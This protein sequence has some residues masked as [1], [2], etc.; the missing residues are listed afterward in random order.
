MQTAATDHAGSVGFAGPH[1]APVT[2]CRV[3]CAVVRGPGQNNKCAVLCVLGGGRT[4]HSR[5]AMAARSTGLP[6]LAVMVSTPSKRSAPGG[7]RFRK[8][9]ITGA[10]SS[11][12]STLSTNVSPTCTAPRLP[13]QPCPPLPYTMRTSAHSDATQLRSVFG[14]R[15]QALEGS[16]GC[17]TSRC[18]APSSVDAR[19]RGTT[20]GSQVDARQ[21]CMP[22]ET[23]SSCIAAK[24]LLRLIPCPLTGRLPA[25]RPPVACS[26]WAAGPASGAGWGGEAGQRAAP[27]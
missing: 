13:H 16:H 27:A 24:H 17:P 2:S 20:D 18:C 6:L 7:K 25:V 21:P 4:V 5:W 3:L 23:R 22:K 19:F 10:D 8:C 1:P 15:S 9:F 12:P 11:W 26:G 14:Q